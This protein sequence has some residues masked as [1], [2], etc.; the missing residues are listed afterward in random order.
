MSQSYKQTFY[1]LKFYK[2]REESSQ[3]MELSQSEGQKLIMLL[4]APNPP[5]FV[6]VRGSLKAVSSIKGVDEDARFQADPFPELSATQQS[7]NAK[8]LEFTGQKLLN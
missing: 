3:E 6:F 5:K 8:F 7:I 4:A 1:T 2:D